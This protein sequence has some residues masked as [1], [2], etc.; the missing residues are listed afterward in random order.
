MRALKKENK[1]AQ[2]RGRFK[3]RTQTYES[4]Y[5]PTQAV[6]S[7]MVDAILHQIKVINTS[8]SEFYYDTLTYQKKVRAALVKEANRI[9][10]KHR[11]DF[12]IPD[13][14]KWEKRP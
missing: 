5:T 3:F 6:A 7:I 10:D 2:G 12:L 13:E 14:P 1:L 4:N 9:G 11:M 8:E